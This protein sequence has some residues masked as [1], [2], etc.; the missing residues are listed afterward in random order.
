MFGENIFQYVLYAK[1]YY[2]NIFKNRIF[3]FLSLLQNV[4]YIRRGETLGMPDICDY[5]RYV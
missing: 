1:S 2:I 4:E 3:F 5:M